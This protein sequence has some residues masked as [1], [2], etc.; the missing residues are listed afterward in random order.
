MNLFET[1]VFEALD[2]FTDQTALNAVRFYTNKSFFHVF[3][4]LSLNRI[5]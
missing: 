2:N 5:E 1:A 4:P 3:I